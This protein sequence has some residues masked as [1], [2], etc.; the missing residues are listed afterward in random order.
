MKVRRN[1][2]WNELSGEALMGV[3]SF[4]SGAFLMT[5]FEESVFVWFLYQG[6]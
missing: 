2:A 5:V 1:L 6:P 4:S 3:N